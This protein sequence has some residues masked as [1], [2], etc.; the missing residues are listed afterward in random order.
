MKLIY[1][2]DGVALNP[3]KLMKN[4]KENPGESREQGKSL[5]TR[6]TFLQVK[7]L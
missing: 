1:D 5:Y 4:Y 7:K 6:P 3:N 2:H